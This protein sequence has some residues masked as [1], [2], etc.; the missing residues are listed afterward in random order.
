MKCVA[1][2]D[3]AYDK[4]SDRF[5]AAVVVLRLPELEIIEQAHAVGWVKFPYIPGLLSFRES[6][7]LLAAFAKVRSEPDVLMFDGQGIAHPRGLGLA[8][9]VGLLLDKPA[10]GCAKSRLVGEHG[11]VGQAVGDFMPLVFHGKRVGAVLRTRKGVKPVF[12]SPGHRM[13]LK[14]AM[15]IVRKTCRGFRIPEPTRQAHL[16]VNRLRAQDEA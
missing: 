7:V 8:S 2:A 10:I 1:G 9:H 11:D 5:Y 6:P 3:V 13:S 15:E 16:L 4:R 14:A 12:V